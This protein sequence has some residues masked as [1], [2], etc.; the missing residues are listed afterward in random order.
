[1]VLLRLP[2][3]WT[4][5]NYK[6]KDFC[7]LKRSWYSKKIKQTTTFLTG[8]DHWKLILW[9]FNN[10]KFIK[11]TK[12]KIFKQSNLK[13]TKINYLPRK[14]LFWIW[15]KFL[16]CTPFFQVTHAGKTLLPDH[17]LAVISAAIPRFFPFKFLV[18][19]TLWGV[20]INPLTHRKL[21][22]HIYIFEKIFNINNEII[23]SNVNSSLVSALNSGQCET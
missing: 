18:T 19:S 12:F 7:S 15:L 9:V 6:D 10:F 16:F 11:W 4:I 2:L 20:R 14:T 3:S 17:Q 23:T 5:K 13:L 22:M 8:V 1:M 21:F